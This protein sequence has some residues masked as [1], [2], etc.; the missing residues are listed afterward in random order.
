MHAVMFIILLI[1]NTSTQGPITSPLPIQYKTAEQCE[2][3]KNN[4]ITNLHNNE[5]KDSLGYPMRSVSNVGGMC[6]AIDVWN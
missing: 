2:I 1:S 4:F 5:A 3:A 6:I